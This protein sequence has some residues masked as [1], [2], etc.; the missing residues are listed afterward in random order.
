MALHSGDQLGPYEVIDLLGSGGMGEV[1]R[2]RDPRLKREVAVK[3][4]P[5]EM[6]GDAD[7]MR[8]FEQEARAT[9]ALNHPNILAIY[10]VGTFS[11]SPFLVSEVLKGETLEKRLGA[12]ALPAR[13]ATTYGLQIAHGLAAA[14]A[15]GI[16]HRDL[17]PGNIFLTRDGQIK[18]LDFGLA[19]L[20]PS[21]AESEPASA[22]T[23]AASDA[24]GTVVGMILGTVGYMSPEQ[25]RGQPADARSDIFSFGAILYEMLS[26]KKAFSGATSADVLSAILKDEPPELHESS[27]NILQRSNGSSNIAWKRRRG[28]ASNRSATWRLIWNRSTRNRERPLIFPVRRPRPRVGPKNIFPPYCWES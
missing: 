6:A 2:C 1:Y 12:G 13:K 23:V 17:K 3:V 10:D 11:G 24:P 27:R 7:R 9:A 5:A 19:K 4:L 25:V 26:G 20:A 21:Q 28:S 22:P 15:G 8:R 18:I 16:T 14:H